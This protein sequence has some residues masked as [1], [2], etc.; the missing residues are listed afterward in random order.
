MP[1]DSRF[2]SVRFAA[3]RYAVVW[4]VYGFMRLLVLLP[5]R[6]QIRLGKRCGAL[7]GRLMRARREIARRNL[8]LCLPELTAQDRESLLDRHFEA[9]GASI[10]ETA[11]GWFGS[12]D[13]IRPLI[14]IEGREHLDAALAKGRGAILF[15]GHL[16]SLELPPAVL[17]ELW[18]NFCGMYKPQ[19]NPAMNQLM[20]RGRLRNVR[21]LFAKDNVRGML[22]ALKNNAVV[23]YASDQSYGHKG[24]ALIRF[25]NEPAMTNT[26]ICRIAK[27]SGAAVLPY[28]YRRLPDDS[29]YVVDI[30][31]PLDDFP[32]DDP[33]HDVERLT[34]QLENYIRLC[35]EQYLWIH[36]RFKGRPAPYPDVYARSAARQ[37]G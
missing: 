29:G 24:S 34:R 23:W 22:K 19:R 6:W 36:Q 8:E 35:P 14:R 32:S 12:V 1:S 27:S 17:G 10:A 7:A 33:A 26:A 15:T 4:V 21:V 31:A 28:F 18:P 11:M 25:F 37:S 2:W 5:F 20:N 9:L 30:G 3:L 13:R 16:T